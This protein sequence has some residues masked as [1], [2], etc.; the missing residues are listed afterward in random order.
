MIQKVLFLLF[1]WTTSLVYAQNTAD[2]K[3]II[4]IAKAKN[5]ISLDGKLDEADWQNAEVAQHFFLNRPFDSSFAKLDAKVKLTFDDKFL[6]VGAICFQPSNSYTVSS[7]KRDFEGGTSDVFTMNFDTY[8]DRL[9]GFHFAVSPLN[10]QREAAIDNGENLSLVWDN[11][12]YSQVTNHA[13]YWELEVAIPFSTLRYKVAEGLNSWRCNFGR[14]VLNDFQVSTWCPVPRNFSPVN[15]AFTGV[16]IWKDAPPKPTKNI[17]LIPYI[18][19]SNAKDFPRDAQSLIKQVP[20]RNNSIA[21]GADAKIAITPALNLDLTYN[22][23]F[24]QVEVDRQVANLSRFELF[25]PERRQFFIE[26]SDLF[27]RW[28]FPDTR[29]FFSR[30]IGLAYDPVREQNRPIP[31]I[32]GARLSGKLN[33]NLRVG[34][35]NMQTKKIDFGNDKVL[36]AANFTVATV[37]QKVFKRSILG[38]VLVNKQNFFNGLTNGQKADYRQFSRVAGVEFNGFSPD[39]RWETETYYHRSFTPQTQGASF[40]NFVGYNTPVFGAGLG[41]NQM[42][43][44]YVSDAGFVPR[45]GTRNFYTFARVARFVRGEKAKKI[46][47]FGLRY[48]G[49]HN[50]NWRGNLLDANLY[51]GAFLQLPDQSEGWVGA[52]YNYTFLF[53]EF[54]PT[55]AN[56]NPN[57]DLNKAIV[58]LPIGGYEYYNYS[59]GYA[60]SNVRNFSYSV[61]ATL[62][63][64]FNGKSQSIEGFFAYRFQPYG[65]IQ[66]SYTF[67]NIELPKPYNS[68][69]YWLIGPQADFAFTRNLFFRTFLQYNT[70]T[71]NVNI[72]SRL[73]WRFRPVSDMFL[74]YT[75]NYF[76]QNIP[77]YPVNAFS[78]KNRALVFKITY[79]LNV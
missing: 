64:Y 5:K 18:T 49:S 27:D 67:Y 36:P 71:N 1:V 61:N 69:N 53:S 12:W 63:Q 30:R 15:L 38:A 24:S 33:Q 77:N 39:G 68:I 32:A 65:S 35:L 50:L 6:Y 8:Q 44:N 40:A 19:A 74:V 56:F 58:S 70:Q 57:P 10:V 17:S 42:D 66:L 59:L 75:N 45:N 37:Q 7:L 41:Y 31:I 60:S 46:N 62:G 28:G 34:L 55:N 25:F 51:V 20:T 14:M 47:N 16:L 43:S 11:K 26:N 73:Q 21:F 52:N 23:D 48:E 9:N 79:W 2:E 13:D 3:Y 54:D 22:P 76:A 72:N 4:H 29:P 78:I